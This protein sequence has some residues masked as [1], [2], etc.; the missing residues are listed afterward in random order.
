MQADLHHI[1]ADKMALYQA[2]PELLEALVAIQ[3]ILDGEYDNPALLKFG[4]ILPN[5]I[6][7]IASIIKIAIAKAEGRK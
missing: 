3:A 6:E 2:A 7:D 1:P 5:R 4:L